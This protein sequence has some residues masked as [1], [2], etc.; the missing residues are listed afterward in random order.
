MST[1]HDYTDTNRLEALGGS[2]YEM[3]DGQPNIKGWDV[4]DINRRKIGEVDEL[5]FNP[6]SRRVR[7]MVVDL[8][9]N[10]FN[11]ASRKIAIPVGVAELHEHDDEVLLPEVTAVHLTSLPAYETGKPL[12][13]D[14][15]LAIRNAF[16][17]PQPEVIK[18]AD[19][20]EHEHFNQNRFYG[21]RYQPQTDTVAN[22]H[23]LPESQHPHSDD[24][25]SNSDI[26]RE[27]PIP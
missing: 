19:F 21:R 24:S 15:E 1:E 17:V 9:K 20:Y 14:R 8:R 10:D 16:A 12:T 13:H 3:A 11:L 18:G 22:D 26:Y 6:A 2:D 5:L 23:L 4:Y 7:Y 25:S 27:K